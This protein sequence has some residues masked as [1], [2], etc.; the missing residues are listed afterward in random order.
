M[1]NKLLG[2]TV[3]AMFLQ[4]RH[5]PENLWIYGWKLAVITHNLKINDIDGINKLEAKY[6]PRLSL[7][8]KI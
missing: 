8:G 3:R 5:V 7:H 4:A 6:L 2:N 1:K